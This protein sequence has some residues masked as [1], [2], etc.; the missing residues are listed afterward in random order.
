MNLRTLLRSTALISLLAILSPAS[1]QSGVSAHTKK[2]IEGAK[3]EGKVVWYTTMTITES[4]KMLDRFQ[5][6]YPF[7]KDE[8]L[9]TG[10]GP[11]LNRM[12]SEGRAG[13]RLFDV[14]GI[15][16][17]AFLSAKKTGLIGKYNSPERS[18]VE[19]DLKD[20]EGYWTA[21]YGIA[22]VLGYN[23]QLVKPADVPKNY[24]ALQAGD[25]A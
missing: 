13:R 8:L 12:L 3:K 10:G 21:A 15:R 14:V 1:V 24:Q 20:R 25:R 2:L 17:E 11:L 4:K 6:K 23:T 7:I 9:R 5:K 19:Q 16:G 22:L 18:M